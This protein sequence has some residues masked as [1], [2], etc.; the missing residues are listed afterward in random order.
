MITAGKA[1]EAS[2]WRSR[3]AKAALLTPA[4][5][6]A[7]GLG[8]LATA[9]G[10]SSSQGVAQVDSTGTTTSSP[11]SQDGARNA[12][13]AAYSACM[14][15]N[16]VRKFPDPD[17]RGRIRISKDELNPNSPQYRAALN[18]CKTLL[19]PEP[20]PS[21]KQ[22]AEALRLGLEYAAC[23]REHGVPNFPDPGTTADGHLD[24]NPTGVHLDQD[25]PR[26]K[27][28]DRTCIGL[29]RGMKNALG[30]GRR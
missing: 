28:A 7:A 14:R 4:L 1:S 23:M 25:A 9:C 13:P 19:P 16:G 29:G 30:G 26:F 5:A 18:A 24:P 15:R 2:G 20:T 22:L 11:D 6:V 27:A 10:G 8:L 21:Q 3:L 12:D 17:A